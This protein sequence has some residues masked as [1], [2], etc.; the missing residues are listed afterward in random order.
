MWR[1]LS[2]VGIALLLIGISV[3]FHIDS[4]EQTRAFARQGQIDAQELDVLHNVIS[5]IAGS[6]PGTNVQINSDRIEGGLNFY[7]FDSRL[8]KSG[9]IA[10]QL[11]RNCAF[12]RRN[13]DM[14]C[15]AALVDDFISSRRLDVVPDLGG[16]DWPTDKPY[17]TKPISPT[18]LQGLR[19]AMS[20]WVL[21]HEVGHYLNG[22][23]EGHFDEGTFLDKVSSATLLQQRELAADQFVLKFFNEPAGIDIGIYQFIIQIVNTEIKAKLCPDIDLAQVC[24]KVPSFVGISNPYQTL[25]YQNAMLHPEYLIRAI[26]LLYLSMD[27]HRELEPFR[28]PVENIINDL[29]LS[30]N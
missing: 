15:D 3:Y 13:M 10:K 8:D 1:F 20:S 18:E 11:V 29:K 16:G 5:Q 27:S 21:A 7:V 25:F 12:I 4:L 2:L 24:S 19:R 17:P 14:F 6:L 28:V 22:D 26:R 23:A 30:R 9:R